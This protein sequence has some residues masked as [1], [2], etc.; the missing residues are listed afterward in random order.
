[1]YL[2]ETGC[3]SVDYI[4]LAQYRA[5]LNTPKNLGIR[6][7]GNFVI[8]WTTINLPRITMEL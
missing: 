7:A 3:D 5:H 6:K 1:M 4:L 2:E 8:S